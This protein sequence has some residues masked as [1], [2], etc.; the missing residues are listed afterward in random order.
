VAFFQ[1]NGRLGPYTIPVGT[2]EADIGNLFD[3]KIGVVS[4][5]STNKDHPLIWGALAHET[6]GHD[7]LHADSDLLPELSAG[8]KNMFG[9]GPTQP[10]NL[11]QQQLLGILW[12]YWIDEAASDVYGLLNIGPEFA[13]NLTAFFAGLN[14]DPVPSMR[15]DSG[16]DESGALDPHPTDLLRIHL[17]IGV[18]ENLHGL[19]KAVR[20]QYIADLKALAQLCGHGASAVRLEGTIR[21]HDFEVNVAQSLPL[22]PMQDAARQ[23]GAFIS[24]AK[25]QAFSNDGTPHSVQ[26]IETWD[27]MDENTARNISQKLS[28]DQ[29][30]VNLGDDAQLIAGATLTLIAE[31]DKY[32]EVTS[33]LDAAL[34]DSFNTDPI[35]GIPAPHPM[36]TLVRLSEMGKEHKGHEHS[37]ERRKKR[38]KSRK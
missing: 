6:G 35:W 34:D 21:V 2:G 38:G 3:T 10:G 22:A 29:S 19:A 4:L 8:V 23:V 32:D 27:D 31:P 5:P 25:L 36:F 15:T 14:R 30:V 26:E 13:F 33:Q 20:D 24:T 17:A 9:G 37:E 18:I 12:S 7:V 11:N 1:N 16:P 28:D